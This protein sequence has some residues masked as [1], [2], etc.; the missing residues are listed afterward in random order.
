[1]DKSYRYLWT[2]RNGELLRQMHISEVNMGDVRKMIG[3]KSIEWKIKRRML[4]RIEH[5]MHM[6]NERLTKEIVLGRWEE[7][8]GR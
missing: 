5:V 4:E 1:M 8:E 6:G 7:L 2:D 3:V